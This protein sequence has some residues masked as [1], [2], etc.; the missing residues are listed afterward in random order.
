MHEYL[1]FDRTPSSEEM[2]QNLADAEN[3]LDRICST[4]SDDVRPEVPGL[5]VKLVQDMRKLDISNLMQLH[6]RAGSK[7]TMAR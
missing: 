3:T 1:I 7:C 5:F 4:M 6:R 2:S